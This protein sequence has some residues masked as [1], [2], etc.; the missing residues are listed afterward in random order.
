MGVQKQCL[1]K[2]RETEL[3]MMYRVLRLILA[4]S[5]LTLGQHCDPNLNPFSFNPDVAL[6]T[7]D[8]GQLCEIDKEDYLLDPGMNSMDPL[9][10]AK[11]CKQQN[12]HEENDE[13]KC[14]YYRMD[15]DRQA[16]R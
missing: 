16:N 14:K 2:Q 12:E 6:I 4:V 9:T 11:K 3:E 13:K 10:C 8:K 5:P 7:C 15:K 1:F